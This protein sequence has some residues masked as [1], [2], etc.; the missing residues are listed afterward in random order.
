MRLVKRDDG[1]F[2][3]TLNREAAEKPIT[4]A[5]LEN[6][7]C[8]RFGYCQDEF[9]AILAELDETGYAERSW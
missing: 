4:M 8:G 3:L 2:A 7:L 6:V 5:G 1:T 9:A